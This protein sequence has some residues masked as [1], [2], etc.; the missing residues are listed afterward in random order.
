MISAMRFNRVLSAL[1]LLF[2][3]SAGV[4][5]EEGMETV[6]Q[7]VEAGKATVGRAFGVAGE[8]GDID[9]FVYE[10]SERLPRN[11][12]IRSA[13]VPGWGQHFNREPVKGAMM[14][15]TF[16]ASALGAVHYYRQSQDS[17]D[18]YK[19]QGVPSSDLYDD[20]ESEKTYASVLGGVALF[21]WGYSMIDAG[22]GVYRHLYS[23]DRSVDLAFHDGKP[24]LEV[25][26][27]F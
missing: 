25:S 19:A 15:L 1:L 23:K 6:Y 16:F 10:A 4:W 22:R 8:S 3:A 20:Y 21:M 14:G 13:L 7:G 27:R 2:S 26:Q 11:A 24:L 9:Y 12:V 17:Y 18:D 5:A